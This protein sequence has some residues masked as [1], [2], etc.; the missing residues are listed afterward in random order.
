MKA[1]SVAGFVGA[2]LLV[3][4]CRTGQGALSPTGYAPY[5]CGYE[6]KFA[7]REQRSL[8]AADWRL[9]NFR[10]NADGFRP[11]LGSDYEAELF[12]DV[13]DDGKTNSLGVLPIYDLRFDHRRN[14]GVI[15][16]S[17]VPLDSGNKEKELRVLADS[18]VERFSGGGNVMVQIQGYDRATNTDRRYAAKLQRRAE[19][20]VAGKPAHSVT[21]D[22]S[23]VDRLKVDPTNVE[24]RITL[25]LVR[26]GASRSYGGFTLPFPLLLLAGYANAPE[27]YAD[28]ESDFASLMS[29]VSING[30]TG[31]QMKESAR[32]RA[33]APAPTPKPEDAPSS[34]SPEAP[35]E[36][37]SAE[38]ETLD[39]GT[40]AGSR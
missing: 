2:V 31:F 8:M 38:P 14:A 19:G 21:V 39:G 33:P 16:I 30:Q 11:K 26:T 12:L 10:G 37:P 15:W 35:G 28:G 3:S 29:R 1:G 34:P 22:V 20:T 36:L 27:D 4:G 9:D 40:P 13:D 18:L 24:A 7:N 5:D 25:V 17:S 23:N 32:D 6:V